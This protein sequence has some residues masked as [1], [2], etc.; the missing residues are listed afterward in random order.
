MDGGVPGG[1]VLAAVAYS[2]F[3]SGCCRVQHGLNWGGGAI[4][5]VVGSV[6]GGS[7]EGRGESVAGPVGLDAPL[8][9]LGDRGYARAESDR[10]GACCRVREPAILR[11]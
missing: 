3:E 6:G 2:F 8:L 11:V 1:P 5:G 4:G 9:L 10:V 7:T